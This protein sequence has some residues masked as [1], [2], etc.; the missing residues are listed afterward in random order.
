MRLSDYKISTK[1]LLVILILGFVASG[2]AILGS[3]GLNR[4]TAATVEINKSVKQIRLGAQAYVYV[5]M[6]SRGEYRA[7]VAPNEIGEIMPLIGKYKEQFD[8]RLTALEESVSNDRKEEINVIRGLY[9]EY[10]TLADETFSLAQK[11]KSSEA[12]AA[13]KEIYAAVIAA[14]AK[15][16]KTTDEITA[17]NVKLMEHNDK[18][19]EQSRE[20]ASFLMKAMVILAVG[21]IVVGFALGMLISKKGIVEPIRN[22]VKCLAN[23]A[24]GQ[25]GIDIYGTERKDE[26]GEIAK[27]TLVFKEN[28]IKAK[29]LES[30]E[31]KE[32]VLKEERQRKR[33][34]A[35]ERF[36]KAMAD[37]VK[38]VASAATEL[39]ASAQSLAAT[40]EE[41]S[42][43]S[44]VVA[45]ASEQTTANV[46][47]VASASEEM[48]ASIAEIGQQVIRSSQIAN[49][50]VEDAKKAGDSVGTLVE[51]ARKIGDVTAVI[52]GIAEQTNLLALNAT[53]EAARAGDA[54]KG[55]AVVASEVKTL[56]NNSGKA[57]EEISAQIA[58]IQQI[59]QQSAVAIEKICK[60]IQEMDQISSAISAAVQEQGTATKEI[61]HNATE[62][63]KGTSEVATNISSV[64]DAANSTGASSHQVLS[65]AQELAKQ[66]EKLKVEFE[67]FATAMAA[68]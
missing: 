16:T 3:Y 39:Q 7:A 34:E 42:K 52:S 56:A 22:I 24:E 57:T 28:M 43:Q 32:R 40:A 30:A 46:A 15:A 44:A 35:T 49:T 31:A 36:E 45:A 51:A 66:A 1:V 6:V 60:V 2:I 50:A 10:M 61:A 48:T 12:S 59:S 5:L 55:F 4:V 54:G 37:I 33:T 62:A 8:E 58:S 38:T 25:L 20:M 65:A 23:L 47:T 68:A 64:N 21:G 67:T 18:I 27:T 53:I 17:L 19:D 29:E 14:R 63:S 41:T 13:Q 9:N 26:V 11:H